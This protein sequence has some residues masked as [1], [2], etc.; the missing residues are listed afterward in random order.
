MGL[1]ITIT[2]AAIP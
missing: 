2:P 1:S